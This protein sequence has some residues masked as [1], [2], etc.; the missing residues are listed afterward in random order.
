MRDR[1]QR[2]RHERSHSRRPT[3]ATTATGNALGS[4]TARGEPTHI[5]VRPFLSR[6]RHLP[7]S[8]WG[9]LTK[10]FASAPVE[11][12]FLNGSPDR[13]SIF[14]D[15]VS[16]RNRRN[17]PRKRPSFVSRQGMILTWEP[18][19]CGGNPRFHRTRTAPFE[20]WRATTRPRIRTPS[21]RSH[22]T[23]APRT[24]PASSMLAI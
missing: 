2:T 22:T 9:P 24:F 3:R 16:E 17:A 10:P 8:R 14:V 1:N 7:L 12:C 6:G 19:A 20:P 21:L 18:K 23:R 5:V 15:I 13:V 11:K 4:R